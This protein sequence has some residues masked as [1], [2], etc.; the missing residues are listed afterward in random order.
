MKF[1]SSKVPWTWFGRGALLLV[2]AAT[3]VSYQ[4]W[5]PM[6]RSWVAAATGAL[7]GTPAAAAEDDHGDGQAAQDSLHLTPQG[8]RNLGLTAEFLQP[9]ALE[10]YRRSI[11]V[12]AVIVERPGRTHLDVATPMTAI[13]EHVHALPGEIVRPGQLLFELR[14][15]HEDL[16][17]L[18]TD[19]LKTLGEVDVEHR[20]IERLRVL[21]DEGAVAGVQLLEHE[22][23]R[24][25]LQAL[26]NAQREALHLHGLSDEQITRIT[27]DRRLLRELRIVAPSPDEHSEQE[28]QL[29]ADSGSNVDLV[30]L[31]QQAAGTDDDAAAVMILQT[32]MVHKGQTVMAGESLCLLADYRELYIEGLGFEQ[33]TAELT[34]AAQRGWTASA[35]FEGPGGSERIV[36]GLEFAF[37]SNEV[38]P[39]SRTLPFYVRLSNEVLP[40]INDATAREPDPRFVAWRYRLG[41]RLELVIP[42]EVWEEQIVLPADAVAEEGPE[43]YV[44][45]Q[46]GDHFNRVPVHVKHRDGRSVVIDYDGSIFPGDVVALRGAHQMQMALKNQSGGAVDPHAGH[47][48]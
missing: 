35:A 29:T 1:K 18:Q 31:E 28:L 14:L 37:F 27:E 15:T 4:L 39:E 43:S 32:L 21:V 2:V 16:V 41:Q 33:D 19:F 9:V 10:T 40:G 7:R 5:L 34:A 12:P 13:V 20:E 44:F 30:S 17:Q 46:N 42:V 26:L 47:S 48:H 23:S 22:Y 24:D 45:L 6:V 38:T 25:R 36:A 8:R 11:T 3:A